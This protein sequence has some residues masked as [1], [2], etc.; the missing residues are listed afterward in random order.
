MPLDKPEVSGT[1]KD[2]SKNKDYCISCF[3]DG[4]FTNPGINLNQ[5]KKLVRK[6][7]EKK[8]MDASTI[9]WLESTLP[10]LKRWKTNTG[11]TQ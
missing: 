1:Q 3:K 8:N 7:M 9:A 11:V 6:Q 5:M 4:A 10:Y 2:G